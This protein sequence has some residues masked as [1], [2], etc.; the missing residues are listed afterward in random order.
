MLTGSHVVT[1]C[2]G[3]VRLICS[4]IVFESRAS[5]IEMGKDMDKHSGW[6]YEE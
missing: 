2:G 5:V 3:R 4:L 1:Q 6:I